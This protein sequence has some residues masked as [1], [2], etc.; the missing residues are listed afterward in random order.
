[1]ATVKDIVDRVEAELDKRA[2]TTEP[3][4]FLKLH[5]KMWIADAYWKISRL[6]KVPRTVEVDDSV[7]NLHEYDIPTDTLGQFSG[8]IS[9]ELDGVPCEKITRAAL[10]ASF[11]EDWLSPEGY[12]AGKWFTKGD[13]EDTFFLV[14]APTTAGTG[15]IRIERIYRVPQPVEDDY[16]D[17]VPSA[18]EEFIPDIPLSVAGR[19]LERTKEGRGAA[20]LAEFESRILRTN[21]LQKRESAIQA[22][23]NRYDKLRQYHYTRTGRYR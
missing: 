9:V 16:S 14:P 15:N 18:F 10:K 21:R 19:A 12:D 20:L 22:R 4:G 8:I 1:M 3:S 23:E 2:R 13:D 17:T 7:V 5:W 6:L 11:Q